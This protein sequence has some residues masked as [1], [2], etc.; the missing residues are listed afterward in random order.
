L[1]QLQKTVMNN[2]NNVLNGTNNNIIGD[3]RRWI[4]IYKQHFLT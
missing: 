2:N 1:L 4:Y 3:K